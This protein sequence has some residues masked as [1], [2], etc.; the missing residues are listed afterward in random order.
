MNHASL[1]ED[2]VREDCGVWF[3]IYGHIYNKARKLVTPRQ[4]YLQAKIQKVVNRMRELGLPVRLI[5]LKPRQKG[6]TTYFAALVY[7]WL[8][9][10]TTSACVIG[11]QYAQTTEL[12]KMIQ[13]FNQH[14]KFAWG[15]NS[16]ITSREGRFTNGSTLKQETA[17]DVVAGIAG[18]YQVLHATE[19]ARWSEFGV[20][21]AADVL[22]NIL[23][24]VPMLPETV[25]ILESTAEQSSGDFYERW[26]GAT[27]ADAFLSGETEVAQGSYVRVFAPWFEFEDSAL[28]DRLTLEQQNLVEATM[29]K[30]D[31]FAGERELIEAYATVGTDGVQRLGTSVKTITLWEQLAWRRWSISNECKRDKNVFD[32][33]LPHSWS[34]AFQKSGALRFNATGLKVMERRITQRTPEYGVL[35]ES[36]TGGKVV[37]RPTDPQ[38]ATV[39]LFERPLSGRR[40]LE[41]CDPMTG[42]TNTGSKDPD[43]HSCFV[44]RAGYYDNLGR[45]TRPATAARIIQCRFDVDVLEREMWKLARFYGPKGGCRIV[46]ETNKDR[47]LVELLKLRGADLYQRELFNQREQ[48]VTETYGWETTQANRERLI[49]N[50]ARAI[51]EWDRAGEGLDVFCAQAIAQLQHFVRKANG[52]SEAANGWHDDDV[53]SLG[54]GLLLIDHAT[55]LPVDALMRR[56][57]P[58]DLRQTAD[59]GYAANP[60][61]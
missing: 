60:Y 46:V 27:D 41:T 8:R 47:G 20:S 53:L 57:V 56:L 48:R 19:V 36:K 40:Y 51:R 15:N 18:T 44:L 16:E 24:C 13:T 10:R 37:F 30:I 54:I 50:L 11:G 6:S 17:K 34:D 59:A 42:I 49:E 61:S 14:D 7:H 32:R 28:P 45:W 22:A 23:K 43:M 55:T 4:N 3:E 35:E 9:A 1:I 12:Y 39:I 21:N 33:D 5:T 26:L 2:A 29:D 25:V 58:P 31:E 38:E 52:R